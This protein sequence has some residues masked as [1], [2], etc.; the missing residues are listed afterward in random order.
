MVNRRTMG[1]ALEVT[2]EQAAFIQGGVVPVAKPQP[3]TIPEPESEGPDTDPAKP[4]AAQA[5]NTEQA[6]RRSRSRRQPRAPLPNGDEP[7]LGVAN[8]LMQ[9]TTRLSMESLTEKSCLPARS[10]K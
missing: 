4:I 2:P 7:L 9:L 8:L 1:A 10:E 3:A 6:S 5:R